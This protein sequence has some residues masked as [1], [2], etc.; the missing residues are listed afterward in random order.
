MSSGTRAAR[1]R[2]RVR[3]NRQKRLKVGVTLQISRQILL[4]TYLS[5]QLQ[6]LVE[7]LN[8]LQI[9]HDFLRAN[10]LMLSAAVPIE[11]YLQLL[12]LVVR[13]T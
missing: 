1:R 6:H 2:R 7:L 11:L 13:V 8:F 5:N 3:E 9:Y 10:L 12:S 4:L